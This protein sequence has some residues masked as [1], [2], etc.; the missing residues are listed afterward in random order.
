DA[1]FMRKDTLRRIRDQGVSRKL[2]GAEIGGPRLEM[3]VTKWPIEED[4]PRVGQVTSAIYSPRLERNI[5]F[6]W[7][8][9]EK[10]SEGTALAVE[11][12]DGRR[13][14]TV[15]TMPFVDPGKQIPKS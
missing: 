5:G 4:G 15:V 14:A 8:P 7:V 1:E 11:T 3:N 6:A 2:V 10:A 12:P 9:I 13:D